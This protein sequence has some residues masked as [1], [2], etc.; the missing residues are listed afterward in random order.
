MPVRDVVCVALDVCVAHTGYS[1][2]LWRFSTHT[3][4]WERVDTPETNRPSA[5]GEHSMTSV[6]L[7][8]WVYGGATRLQSGGEGDTCTTPAVLLLLEY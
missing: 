6:G 8:L 2:E 7:D 1:N 3:R 4:V 5:R